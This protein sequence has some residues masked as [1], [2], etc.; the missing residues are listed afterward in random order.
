MFE[1]RRAL[2]PACARVVRVLVSGRYACRLAA[3]E[4][5]VVELGVC[6]R[7][8]LLREALSGAVII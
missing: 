5:I 7:V 4:A 2:G 6:F 1:G 8:L 3:S